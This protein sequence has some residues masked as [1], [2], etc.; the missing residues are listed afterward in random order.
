MWNG[1]RLELGWA[2]KSYDTDPGEIQRGLKT[3][4]SC[5]AYMSPQKRCVWEVVWLDLNKVWRG[6]ENDLY[7]VPPIPCCYYD[8]SIFVILE[9]SGSPY[10]VRQ[11]AFPGYVLAWNQLAPRTEAIFT[12]KN[13]N[14][15]LNQSMLLNK[16]LLK[17]WNFNT[18]NA[19]VWVFVQ[20]PGGSFLSWTKRKSLFS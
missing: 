8:S 2:V 3:V 13:P 15:Q 20:R 5:R 1:L 17:I 6:I 19:R 18:F 11:V 7:I 9:I 16:F 12:S 10:A 14:T 4:G